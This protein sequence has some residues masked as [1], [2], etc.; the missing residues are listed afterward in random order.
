M[1]LILF[2]LGISIVLCFIILL[3]PIAHARFVPLN[4]FKAGVKMEVAA[5]KIG[6]SN[7]VSGTIARSLTVSG[8]SKLQRGDDSKEVQTDLNLAITTLAVLDV[9]GGF[10]GPMV[11]SLVARMTKHSAFK[12]T[13]RAMRLMGEPLTEV[14]KKELSRLSTTDLKK[15]L[16]EKKS[17]VYRE[18]E[19]GML[20]FIGSKKLKHPALKHINKA[21]FMLKVKS[22]VKIIG[23]IF[24]LVTIGVNSWS[25]GVAVKR[26]RD[27]STETECSTASITA[28]SLSI[29]SGKCLQKTLLGRN[30]T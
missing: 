26:C 19:D 22:V 9:G 25:L 1:T 14:T 27:N 12:S 7:I 21:K 20:K 29:L 23:P 8:V 5:G 18:F 15:L 28:A 17:S 2:S 16:A 3:A 6:Q 10:I 13:M 11:S 30:S 4:L 24:D